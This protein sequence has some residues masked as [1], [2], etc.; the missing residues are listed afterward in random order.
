MCTMTQ[1]TSLPTDKHCDH[2]K[3]CKFVILINNEPCTG[4][5]CRSAGH[6]EYD[7]RSHSHPRDGCPY[8]NPEKIPYP[9]FPENHCTA[10]L[11]KIRADERE[12]IFAEV[13]DATTTALFKRLEGVGDEILNSLRK[14]REREQE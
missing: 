8:W 5:N 7:S 13:S 3:M 10:V 14:H 1:N 6:Q 2:E 11:S 12:K 9:D 4:A